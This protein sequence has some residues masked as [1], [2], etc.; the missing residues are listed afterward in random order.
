M[1]S[2]VQPTRSPRARSNYPNSLTDLHRY[3]KTTHGNH[4]AKSR[5]VMVRKTDQRTFASL[6]QGQE[7]KLETVTRETIETF[8]GQRTECK[9]TTEKK[10]SVE[11]IPAELFITL[12]DKKRNSGLP[13]PIRNTIKLRATT[14]MD[15]QTQCLKAHNDYRQVHKVQPLKLSKELCRQAQQWADSLLKRNTLVRSNNP[16]G[17]NLYLLNSNST[18]VTAKEIVKSWYDDIAKYKFGLEPSSSEC[19]HFTQVVWKDCKEIGVGI[20]KT[21]GKVIVAVFY[22]PPGNY[23][24]HHVENVPPIG[25]FQNNNE[26]TKSISRL[27]LQTPKRNITIGTSGNFDEDFLE[28]HNKYR[29]LHGVPPLAIDKNLCKISEE[30]AKLLASKNLMEHRK[31]SSYGENIYCFSSTNPNHTIKGNEPVDC[32]YKEIDRHNFSKEPSSLV[33]GHFTQVV[34]KTSEHLGVGVAKSRQG[35]IYVVANYSPAGNFV[36]HFMDNVPPIGSAPCYEE[37]PLQVPGSDNS[38]Y[39][40]FELE[41]LRVHNEYRRKHGASPL[42]LNK[43]LC[44]YAKEWASQLSRSGSLA[45]RVN[46]PYGENIFYAYS[47]DFSVIPTARDAISNWYSEMKDYRFD[48]EAIYQGTL[49]FT[50]IV[51]KKSTEFGIGM[52]NNGKGKTYIVA[53]Y[54]PRGNCIGEFVQNVS[55]PRA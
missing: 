52:A 50:Q 23:V 5:V 22:D 28:A 2:T 17:E 21:H 45:H 7:P 29:K 8:R 39:D 46:S 51:W 54:N 49:H 18:N 11:N 14:T 12:T 33:S 13:V 32:W 6:T 25:G 35:T 53:N 55:R 3:R 34:W 38:E 1:A 44:I 10:G 9:I 30:W 24:G 40:K 37:E 48:V 15:F 26:I 41:G 4:E 42:K 20:A 19:G 31:N 27:S 36:G 16:Y 47:S 43:Q